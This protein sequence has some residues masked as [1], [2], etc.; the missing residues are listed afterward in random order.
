M[1]LKESLSKEHIYY[2]LN[3]INSVL[4]NR[5][6]YLNLRIVGGAALLFN[7]ISA[8]ET[9]DIDVINYIS[10]ELKDICYD[11]SLD[12]NDDALDYIDDF[13]DCEFIYDDR[14]QFSNITISYL[15]VGSVIKTKL[16][17]YQD[18]YKAEK[19]L[20]LLEDVLDV[21]MTVEGI[22]NYL[23]EQDEIPDLYDIEQ[24]LIAVGYI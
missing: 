1:T 21:E 5:N 15:P 6:L 20:Y 7:G 16:K 3:K 22:A 4:Q 8:V 13:K 2:E 10:D 18:E 23:E 14:K 12:I 24:F 17:N 9:V 19:L 11:F